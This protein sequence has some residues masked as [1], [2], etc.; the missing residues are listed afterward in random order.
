ME[1]C[2]KSFEGLSV[3]GTKVD[4]EACLGGNGINRRAAADGADIIGRLGMSR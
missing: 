4:G 3:F 1:E 2:I